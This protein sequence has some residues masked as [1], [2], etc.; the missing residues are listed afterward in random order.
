ML[1]PDAIKSCDIYVMLLGERGGW[2]TP[3]GKLVVEEE[4][5]YARKRKLPVLVYVQNVVRDADAMRLQ[6]LVS[7][8]L[9][10]YFAKL[11]Y[12]LTTLRT[13]SRLQYEPRSS[14]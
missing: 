12:H 5:E 6:S 2:M 11:L 4:Y 8:T 7:T 9:T 1:C 10:A 13:R 14:I 3:S